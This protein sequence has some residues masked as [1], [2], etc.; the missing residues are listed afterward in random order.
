[1]SSTYSAETTALGAVLMTAAAAAAVTSGP[2]T[3][4]KGPTVH[5]STH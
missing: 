1:M 5:T 2:R 3:D 4:N